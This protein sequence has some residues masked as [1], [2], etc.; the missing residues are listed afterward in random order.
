MTYCYDRRAALKRIQITLRDV[1]AWEAKMRQGDATLRASNSLDFLRWLRGH[2]FQRA[3]TLGPQGH[4]VQAI[5]MLSGSLEQAAMDVLLGASQDLDDWMLKDLFDE[6]TALVGETGLESTVAKETISIQ[7]GFTVTIDYENAPEPEEGRKEALDVIRKFKSKVTDPIVRAGFKKALM[8]MDV[9]IRFDQPSGR[10][11]G[12]YDAGNDVVH[13]FPSRDPGYTL[14]HEI[15]HR[16]YQNL[17]P[18]SSIKKWRRGLLLLDE[19]REISDYARKDHN[20]AFA[21]A[22]RQIVTRSPLGPNATK[23]F[24]EVLDTWK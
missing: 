21:E 24:W 7:P 6:L 10:N 18:S 11:P 16:L 13:L 14:I 12:E 20:E 9:Q 2:V 4:R 19:G 3:H 23:L 5:D 1:Q 22:F 15:G 17:L 8:G